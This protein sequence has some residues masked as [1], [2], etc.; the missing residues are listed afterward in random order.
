M[1]LKIILNVVLLLLILLI[2]I[3]GCASRFPT[4]K[5]WSKVPVAQKEKA[6]FALQG[7]F[8][9]FD[10]FM[11]AVGEIKESM[12]FEEIRKLGFS[13]E[14][15]NSCDKI[16]WL[17]ASAIVLQNTHLLVDFESLESV[18]TE[19]K[20]YEGIRCRCVDIKTRADRLFTYFNNH[21]VYKIG[22]NVE[23][24]LIFKN[25]VLFGMNINDQLIKKHERES[26][27]GKSIGDIFS[28]P[29]IKPSLPIK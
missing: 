10:E 26:A 6:E 27:F 13:T 23:L 12:S 17:E 3:A 16:G 18:T 21:D 7:D 4:E 25:K 5:E 8:K 11:K 19:K 14:S 24:T 2:I 28:P 29:E 9:N 1:K 15:K 22:R 20:Q